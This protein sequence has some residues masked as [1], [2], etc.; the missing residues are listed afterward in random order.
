MARWKAWL[1]PGTR[2]LHRHLLLWLLLPQLVLWMAAAIFTYKLAERYANQA[3]DA[4]LST[5][6]RALARQV[7]PSGSGLYIDFPR[8]AQDVIEADPDDRLYYKVSFATGRVHPRQQPDAG[9]GG[10][11]QPAAQ[12][13]LPLRRHAARPPQRQAGREGRH[14]QHR[15]RP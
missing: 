2:S 9:A 12:P 11:P 8:A 3:I 5:A 4:S 6:S 15:G 14:P 10:H 13:A 7:K 1:T